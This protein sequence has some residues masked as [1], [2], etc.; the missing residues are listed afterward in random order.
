MTH[1]EPQHGPWRLSGPPL[2]DTGRPLVLR[3][4]WVFPVSGPP[5]PGGCVAI[6]GT[7]IAAVH[8]TLPQGPVVDLGNVAVLPGLINAH[9]HLELSDLEQ[10]LGQPGISLPEW[11]KKVIRHRRARG[12]EAAH[13]AVELGLAA[14]VRLGTTLL[15]E[16]AQPDW[17]PYLLEQSPLRCVV[18]LELIA[19]TGDRVQGAVAA[20]RAH[21]NRKPH[22]DRVALGLSPHAPYSV[23]PLLLEQAAELSRQGHVPLAMH[24]AES[25]EEIELLEH[26]TGPM[27]HLL[28]QLGAWSANCW[29]PSRPLDYLRHLVTG[30]RLL[31]IHG[32]YLRQAEIDLLAAHR[33]HVAVVYCPR[34]HEY[35]RH[36][37]Y[38]LAQLLDAGLPV[39]LGTDSCASSPNLS[40]LEEMRTAARLHPQVPPHRVL[41]MGTI[42][43]ARALG[44]EATAG[45][46][47]PG[48]AADLTVVA[49]PEHDESDPYGLLFDS[50]LP[51]LATW[52]DGTCIWAD[53]Q[54][55]VAVGLD[56]RR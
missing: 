35:F 56:R 32:N 43:G 10:P 15:G 55:A 40:L 52:V 26:G 50:Q 5:I 42:F 30:H 6:G 38:R 19:P 49:L 25:G 20:A 31:V 51:V 8:A 4:R 11:I 34:T 44:H 14:S 23:C 17:S 37:D 7:K 53:R 12:A 45:S 29:K 18:F 2:N 54:F 36:A 1:R 22:C 3:A 47:E 9:T 16:I 33:E 28:E 41:A 13:Q 46:I 24:V 39:A 48:K 27:R 21:L